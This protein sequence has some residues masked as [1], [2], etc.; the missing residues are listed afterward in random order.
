MRVLVTGANGF[1]GRILCN[2][3][4]QA[5]CK[6]R[7]AIHHGPAARGLADAIETCPGLDLTN[8]KGWSEV[9]TGI[10]IVVHLAA[11]AHI[12]HDDTDDPLAEYR[13]VNTQGALTLARLAAARG[14]SRFVFMSS[15]KVNGEMTL[16][17]P[18]TEND[19]PLPTDPYAVS[20]LEAERGLAKIAAGTGLGC[21][22]LRPPLVYGPG[23]KGNFL[24][25]MMLVRRGIPLP[26]AS[27]ANKRSLLYVGNLVS[28]IERAATSE[29]APGHTYLL[30]DGADVST[31]QLIRLLGKAMGRKPRL[32]PFR[33]GLLL[34]FGKLAGRLDEMQRLTGSLQVDATRITHELSWQPPF[35]LE[36]GIADTA[37]WFMAAAPAAE[38]GTVSP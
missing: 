4:A 28:A 13:R 26:F 12:M 8:E 37:R 22:V 32:M 18:F 24:R 15:V 1:V 2:H 31:P 14:V 17:N 27:L 10:D 21:V 16:D 25:L 7:A 5:G 23:V 19:V 11:R 29:I 6:V 36:Q 33:P 35:T 30:S 20:K 9:L 3:L 38:A 34:A